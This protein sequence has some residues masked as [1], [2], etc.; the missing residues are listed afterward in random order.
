MFKAAKNLERYV[1]GRMRHWEKG[2]VIDLDKEAVVQIFEPGDYESEVKED[3]QPVGV[4]PDKK[5]TKNKE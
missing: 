5:K 2:D 1:G 3:Y 4:N